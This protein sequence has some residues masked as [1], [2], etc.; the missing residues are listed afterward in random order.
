MLNSIKNLFKSNKEK[1]DNKMKYLITGLGNIGAEYAHT[2]H[3]IGFDIL[4]AMA[5][6]KD[7]TFE[8]KRY[9][10]VAVYKFKGRS[11][12]LLKP[13]TY[14]NLSGRAVNYWLQ[15]EKISLTNLLV[16]VDDL[17]LPFGTLRLKP[18]GGDAGHNGLKSIQG[19]LGTN[20]Y[21]RLRF[22][23]G[24][25]F[26]RGQQVD[27][28]LG[29]WDPEEKIILPEKIDLAIQMIKSFGTV[30]TARTMNQFNNK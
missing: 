5:A 11:F 25:N 24:N 18:K 15:K 27:Y 28:V 7:L 23:I 2:R 1:S 22:G 13:N 9:G 20:N 10:A 17:A 30:G 3:N 8:D 14:V 26:N 6:E 16:V 29:R 19:T 12:I 21:A 4:D